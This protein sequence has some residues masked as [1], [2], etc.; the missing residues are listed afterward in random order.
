MG[1]NPGIGVWMLHSLVVLES[2]VPVKMVMASLTDR[3]IT[4]FYTISD[5]RTHISQ[6][7]PRFTSFHLVRVV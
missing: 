5:Q 3:S 1:L 7:E 2:G 4:V 6:P